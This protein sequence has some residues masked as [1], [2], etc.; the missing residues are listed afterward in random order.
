[1]AAN[2]LPR[3]LDALFTLAEDMA[4]GLNTHEVTAGVKQNTQVAMRAAIAAANT[5]EANYAI[6]KAAKKTQTTAVTIA[7]SNGKAFIG[8]ARNVLEPFLGA[9]P[10]AAWEPAGFPA[11]S[12]AIPA[13]QAERQALLGKLRD[14]FTANPARENAPLVITAAQANSLFTA[15]S[16]ARSAA[17]QGNTNAVE[18]KTLRDAAVTA[19]RKRMRG[20]IDELEQLLADEDARWYAFGLNPPGAPATPE[21]PDGLALAGGGPGTVDADWSDAARAEHYRVWKQVVGVDA[22]FVAVGSPTD[23]DF[24]LT[25][26]PSGA[27]VKVQITAVNDAGESQPSTTQQM[28][29][30]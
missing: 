18:K 24:T 2:D 19:L 16:D 9:E 30:P 20:L 10:S 28:V 26:L 11:D 22:D 6:A 29:V 21:V 1:M 4:D 8:T 15:L 14:Y 5:A 3:A 12:L 13:T 7:D 27:T 25:G 23:S 17:N